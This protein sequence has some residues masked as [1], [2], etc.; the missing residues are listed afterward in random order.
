MVSTLLPSSHGSS[1]YP[2]F[3]GFSNSSAPTITEPSPFETING[4]LAKKVKEGNNVIIRY[5]FTRTSMQVT[6]CVTNSFQQFFRLVLFAWH[7][8]I[9]CSLSVQRENG[10]EGEREREINVRGR[11]RLWHP[12]WGNLRKRAVNGPV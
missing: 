2:S 11:E 4:N 12:L 10:G 5:T 7:S 8:V 1:I 9:S 3:F 6:I